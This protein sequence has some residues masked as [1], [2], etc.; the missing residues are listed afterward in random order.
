[1]E[2]D[3]FVQGSLNDE[4][5]IICFITDSIL[6]MVGTQIFSIMTQFMEISGIWDKGDTLMIVNTRKPI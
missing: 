3:H 5:D 1:M 6:Y 2:I 4:S